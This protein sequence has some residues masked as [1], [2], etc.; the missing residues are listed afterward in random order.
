MC[1]CVSL[2]FAVGVEV[3]DAAGPN[4]GLQRDDLVEW[5][6]E[7]LV[8]VEAARG[9]V[10]RLVGPEVMMAKGK[11]LTP[12][13]HPH[14]ETRASQRQKYSNEIADVAQRWLNGAVPSPPLLFTLPEFLDAEDVQLVPVDMG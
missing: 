12:I 7:Q 2:T 8:V 14:K 5:H 9:R 3:E 6:T 11:P 13:G 1:A 10:V 4:H